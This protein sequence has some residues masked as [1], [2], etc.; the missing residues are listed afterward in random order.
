[1][2]QSGKHPTL[3]Q[4]MISWV[5]EF[6]PSIGLCTD[7]AEPA[8]DSLSLSAPVLIFF[9]NKERNKVKKTNKRLVCSKPTEIHRENQKVTSQIQEKVQ[10]QETPE[11]ISSLLLK[12][13]CG[14]EIA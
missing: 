3:A 1:M 5:P 13:I 6:K 11:K 12:L 14:T 2:A 7:N 4:V 8:W 10:A 9:P